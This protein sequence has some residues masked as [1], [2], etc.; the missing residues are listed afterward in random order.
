MAKI[1]AF[2][3]NRT[4]FFDENT[5]DFEKMSPEVSKN[6]QKWPKMGADNQALAKLSLFLAKLS[7][8]LAKLSLFLAKLSPFFFGYIISLRPESYFII[9]TYPTQPSNERKR[10]FNTGLYTGYLLR[11]QRLRLRRRGAWTVVAT[12]RRPRKVFFNPSA[13]ADD[14]RNHF[15]PRRRTPTTPKIVFQPVG[16][17]R[18]LQKVFFTS[19]AHADSKTSHGETCQVFKTWQV[20]K[21][22]TVRTTGSRTTAETF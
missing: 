21:E 5:T 8:F 10:F 20:Q 15:S 11:L 13:H 1:S 2:C 4:R 22:R 16:A 19:S 18:Q 9:I 12:R 7:P 6:G 3:S 17:R 14:S